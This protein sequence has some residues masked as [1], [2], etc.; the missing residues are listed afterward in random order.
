MLE[1]LADAEPTE[2]EAK[3]ADATIAGDDGKKLAEA[4]TWD[5]DVE[6]YNSHDRVQ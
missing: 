1:A 5:I 2:D 3:H 4:V 6:T